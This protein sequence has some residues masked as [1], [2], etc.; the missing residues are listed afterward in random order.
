MR[1]KAALFCE[2]DSVLSVY[3]NGRRERIA[4]LTDLYPEVISSRNFEKHAA[5]LGTVEVVFSTWGMPALS[6]EQLGRLRELKV[7]F[8]AAGSVKRF[9][10]PILQRGIALVSAW[11]ANACPVAEFT[12][13]QILLANKGYFRNM[14]DSKRPGARLAA[15]P[16]RARGNYWRTIALLG[17]GQVGRR[18]ISLL[19]S[20][21]LNV[22]VFD[23]HLDE[24]EA[25]AL[26]VGKVSLEEAFRRGDVVSNHLADVP[27]TRGTLN[28]RLFGSMPVNAAFINTGRGATVVEED[29]VQV[30]RER[31]DLT[32]LLDVTD[33]EPPAP[34][35]AFYVLPNVFLS[36]HIAGS[37]GDE[38]HRMA[39]WMIE[40]FQAWEQGSPLRWRVTREMLDTMA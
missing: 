16:F 19:K 29:L 5:D 36:S 31:P 35:S 24:R 7:L 40:E 27:A 32:A 15:K 17:A 2:S 28:A 38:V 30:L 11:A 14:R 4:E 3:G 20:F 22:I 6:G 25:A 37:L 34:D 8:Y 10:L 13:G 1:R 21:S 12:L 9:A 39:D 18:V 33:P 26:G 23:P